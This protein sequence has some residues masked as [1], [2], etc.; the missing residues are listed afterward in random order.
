ML[1]IWNAKGQRNSN[2]SKSNDEPK[3]VQRIHTSHDGRWSL[4]SFQY[5]K[6][7]REIDKCT[8]L[9][10]SIEFMI[11][12]LMLNIDRECQVLHHTSEIRFRCDTVEIWF[13][14]YHQAF[15]C[16]QNEQLKTCCFAESQWIPCGMPIEFDLR[17]HAVEFN[18]FK[19]KNFENAK[20]MCRRT[21][22]GELVRSVRNMETDTWNRWGWSQV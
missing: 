22:T 16:R 14:N 2:G 12:E 11:V 4:N 19:W 3:I 5:G 15:H 7:V 10:S 17:L 9:I 18:S 21:W 1:V 6:R 13:G 8:S 20:Q